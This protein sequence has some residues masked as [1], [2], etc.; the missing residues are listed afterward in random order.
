MSE[1]MDE[2]EQIIQA[3]DRRVERRNAR[4]GFFKAAGG[5]AAGAAGMAALS[6]CGGGSSSSSG[7]STAAAGVS[8]QT[9]TDT[10]I[11]NFALQLEYLEAQFYSY[12]ANGTGL[13]DSMLSGTGTRG[14]LNA[15]GAQKVPFTDPVVAGY[16]REIAADEMSHVNFLRSALTTAA[17]AM[18]DIDISSTG[19]FTT[20][21]VGAKL[22]TQAQ[23]NAGATFSPYISDNNFLLGAFIFEDVGVTA[24]KGAAPL[25]TNKTYLSAAAGIL[26]VEAYHAGL[27]RTVLYARGVNQAA[28]VAPV[29]VP[30]SM[31]IAATEGISNLRDSV[32]GSSDDDQGITGSNPGVLAT[33]V[34]N[35]VPTDAN[36]LAFD[37]TVPN[38]LNVVY[39]TNAAVTKG[40]FFPSGVNAGSAAFMTSGAN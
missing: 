8:P 31:V 16:A 4:R 29:G 17:V 1:I 37:R 20:L 40:G 32:D 14:Q 7:G 38:V 33:A 24:Y 36:A 9:D 30:N 39:G 18:P 27:I 13:P 15:T 35:I 23:V 10:A 2:N 6:A 5:F 34:S 28:V 3:L 11:L 26:A 12:A 22:L 21:A 19:V 25:L